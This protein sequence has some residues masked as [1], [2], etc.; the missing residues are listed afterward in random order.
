MGGWIGL[1][2]DIYVTTAVFWWRLRGDHWHRAADRTLQE[3]SEDPRAFE[4]STAVRPAAAQHEP[5][6]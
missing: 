1:C 3:L 2:I 5:I 4:V 6:G